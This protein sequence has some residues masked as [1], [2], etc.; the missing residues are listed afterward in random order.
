MEGLSVYVFAIIIITLIVTSVLIWETNATIRIL[1]DGFYSADPVFCDESNLDMLVIYFDHGDGYIM[2][3][4]AD[5]TILL[6]DMFQYKMS[7]RFSFNTNI[8]KPVTFTITFSGLDDQ[9]FFPAKQTIEFLPST[10]RIKLYDEEDQSIRGIL[11]KNNAISDV[12]GLLDLPQHDVDK[13]SGGENR[14]GNESGDETRVDEN[15]Y[16][17]TRVDE[18]RVDENHCDND[19]DSVDE[20]TN[21]E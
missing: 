13:S 18:T 3:R 8:S 1:F 10:Q 21:I 5:G 6:N 11:Y 2:M 7:S 17:E 19:S 14:S 4:G 20:I 16:D 12:K 9:E 15:R